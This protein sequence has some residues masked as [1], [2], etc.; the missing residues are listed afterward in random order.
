MLQR[1]Y[2]TVA[3]PPLCRGGLDCAS[4]EQPRGGTRVYS[5][6]YKR[7]RRINGRQALPLH[8]RDQQSCISMTTGDFA[9]PRSTG[10]LASNSHRN[11]SCVHFAQQGSP[12]RD[13]GH[14]SRRGGSMGL[15]DWTALRQ[16]RKG[17]AAGADSVRCRGAWGGSMA[18]LAS[19]H[20]VP[21]SAT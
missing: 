9:R 10:W 21:K 19:N 4:T 20:S 17:L 2:C 1:R 12:P 8:G 3:R 15:R 6:T 18:I 13:A 7:S 11:G 14:V 16:Q 5:Y